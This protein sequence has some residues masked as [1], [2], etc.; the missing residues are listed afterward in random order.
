MEL[1]RIKKRLVTAKR[2][3]KLLKDKR[4]E[5]V[6]QFIAVIREN[7]ALRRE[8]ETELSGAL[9]DFAM[10]R[11]VMDPNALEEAVLYPARQAKVTT[12]QK[13]IL[14]VRVPTI[15]V[16]EAS[17]SET[18]LPYGL[19]ETSAQLDGAI[20]T[21][22][23]VLP[24]LLRLAEVEKTCDLLAD[25]IE[26]TRRRVN[27]LEYVMIPQLIETIHFITMK[28]DENERGALTRLMKVKD[29]IAARD[30]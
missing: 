18:V 11:A 6:R 28:L 5:M 19:A 1:T 23:E 3:H 21:M 24:K 25:E 2:G 13:N 9:R 8:V 4:D 26:K 17:L 27:A 15:T 7:Y 16:D 30:A 20:A 22:A 12:G 14:S 10:A 29:M